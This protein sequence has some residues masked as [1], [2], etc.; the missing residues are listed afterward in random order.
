MVG[1]SVL[2]LLLLCASVV[3]ADKAPKI[4]RHRDV[5][6][7]IVWVEESVAFDSAGRLKAAFLNESLRSNL[8]DNASGTCSSF[9]HDSPFELFEPRDTLEEVATSSRAVFSGQVVS[10]ARGLSH[11]FPG[12]LIGFRVTESFRPR[13]EGKPVPGEPGTILYSFIAGTEFVTPDGAICASRPDSVV[14]PERGDTILVFTYLQP[15]DEA[16]LIIPLESE[17][18]LIVRRGEKRIFTPAALVHDVG[19]LS[20]SAAMSRVKRVTDAKRNRP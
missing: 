8:R 20:V 10:T 3:P 14:V 2:L 18:H 1:H 6:S 17:R 16:N 12:T 5:P 15:I 13:T 11:G 7:S 19:D 4:L 9:M